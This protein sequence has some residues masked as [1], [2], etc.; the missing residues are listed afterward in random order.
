MGRLTLRRIRGQAAFGAGLSSRP[1][2][3]SKHLA[4]YYT[5][6]PESGG[7]RLGLIVGKRFAPH[8]VTRNRVKRVLRECF[9][10]EEL[11]GG[12]AFVRVRSPLAAAAF[13]PTF[14]VEVCQLWHTARAAILLAQSAATPD[15]RP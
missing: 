6:S 8:A 3:T 11:G 10:V 13:S 12:A 4:V 2:A 7:T 15:P 9:A 14:N 1:V 5:R